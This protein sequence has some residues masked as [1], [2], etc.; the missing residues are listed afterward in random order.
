MKNG[1]IKLASLEATIK[2]LELAKKNKK[3]YLSQNKE[4][5]EYE[6]DMFYGNIN[7]GK[8][9]RLIRKKF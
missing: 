5:P 7:K 1:S 6:Y 3:Q 4:I 8:V 9:L 2:A